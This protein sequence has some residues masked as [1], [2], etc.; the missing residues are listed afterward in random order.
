[1]DARIRE[2]RIL[3][4]L[5][6]AVCALFAPTAVAAG[7]AVDRLPDLRM[8]VLSD[9]RV[10]HEPTV[11]N[12]D[13]R[14]LRFTAVIMNRG[15]GPFIVKGSR[16]AGQQQMST[17]QVIKRSD[18]TTRREPSVATAKYDV[19]D[20]HKHW[21][22]MDVETYELIPLGIPPEEQAESVIGS[23]VGFC[24]FDTE[25]RDLSMPYSP[26][27]PVYTESGCGVSSSLDI[28]VGLSVGWGDRYSWFLARQWIRVT[29]VPSGNYLLCATADAY[30][31]WQE[32]NDGNNQSWVELQLRQSGGEMSVGVL[33]SGKSSCEDRAGLPPDALRRGSYPRAEAIRYA[34]ISPLYCRLS[35]DGWETS[36]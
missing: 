5:L 20:G 33:G 15:T 7:E 23:K 2:H 8:G 17:E 35:G 27:Y 19:G 18:G 22:V 11:A 10:T 14:L 29:S 12:P 24:F 6:C 28:R 4:A 36:S 1:M 25:G 3:V 9:I 21:H 26:D 16:G 13:R 31:Q 30:G 32:E 34:P